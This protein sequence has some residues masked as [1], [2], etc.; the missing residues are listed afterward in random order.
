MT[1][2]GNR[3]LAERVKNTT[4]KSEGG[5][6][7]PAI[8]LDDDNTG[9]PKEWLVLQVGPGRRNRDGTVVPLEFNPGDRV[10]YL[11][12]TRGA[13]KVDGTEQSILDADGVIA[14]IPKL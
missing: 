7:L 14:V 6:H 11:S 2:L 5:I 13:T 3:F 4:T 12:Y 9:G 8:V 10:L 1:L